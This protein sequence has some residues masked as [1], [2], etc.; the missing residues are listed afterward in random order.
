MSFIADNF[1]IALAAVAIFALGLGVWWSRRE[2]QRMDAEAAE[3]FAPT[4]VQPAKG[5]GGGPV[6]IK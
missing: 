6:P 1:G 2:N 4:D 3:A 5:G